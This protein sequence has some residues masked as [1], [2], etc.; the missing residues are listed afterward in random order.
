MSVAAGRFIEDFNL[1]NREEL[2]KGDILRSHDEAFLLKV[3][4]DFRRFRYEFGQEMAAQRLEVKSERATA[5]YGFSY[6]ESH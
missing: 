1:F 5:P 3:M 4:E 6:A 2:R